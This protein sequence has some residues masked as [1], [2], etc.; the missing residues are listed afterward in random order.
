MKI[1]NYDQNQLK[2]DEEK[3]SL[4]HSTS[5]M[6][7]ARILT[8]GSFIKKILILSFL[9]TAC[10]PAPPPPKNLQQLSDEYWTSLNNLGIP[11]FQPS[12]RQNL[13]AIPGPDSLSRQKIAFQTLHQQL[14]GIVPDSLTTNELLEYKLLN[15]N[16][17]FHLERLALEERFLIDQGNRPISKRGL[18]NVELYKEWYKYYLKRWLSDD[19]RPEDLYAFGKEQILNAQRQIRRI[20]QEMGF[21]D[22]SSGFYKVLRNDTFFLK[23][24]AIV[25][26]QLE[27]LKVVVDTNMEKVFLSY[28]IQDL[29][30][31][32]GTDKEKLSLVGY[33]KEEESTLYFS[34]LDQP[35]NRRNLDWLFLH[36][37]IPG[38]HFEIFFDRTDEIDQ[39]SFRHRSR[40]FYPGYIEGW[41]GYA[42]GLGQDL[43]LYSTLSAELGR[44]EWDLVQSVRIVLDVGINYLGWTN[45]EALKFWRQEII[46]QDAI[47]M[48]EIR[49]IRDRPAQVQTY[50]YGAEQFIRLM[51]KLRE[52][53]GE[54]FNLRAF[55]DKVLKA[56]AMPFG[57]LEEV[58]LGTE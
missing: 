28:E 31:A 23:D 55:H 4:L 11:E 7:I 48:R 39:T 22:D 40:S 42:E 3:G 32:Q 12:Y 25:Q 57:L 24:P 6:I 52:K 30:I 18:F 38:H 19:V 1:I 34:L 56:G 46:N 27:Q 20:Q 37:A 16:V 45:R 29:R 36:E 53:E 17:D 26:Q 51:G 21:A 44:W 14:L 49:K 43:G 15:W 10:Q 58:L 13:L 54:P 8:I 2:C 35:F 41:G 5:I 47:A 50:K 33:Y 9:F